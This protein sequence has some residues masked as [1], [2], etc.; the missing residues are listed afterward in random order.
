MKKFTILA[1]IAL[2]ILSGN[3]CA[4]GKKEAPRAASGSLVWLD[5]DQTLAAA[6]ADAK[7]VVVDVYTDWCGWCKVMDEKTYSDP[8]VSELMQKSFVAVKLNAEGNKTVSYLGKGYTETELARSFNVSGYP[9]TIFLGS[10]GSVLEKIPGYIEAP[11]FK[12]VLDYFDSDSYKN[13]SL[14]QYI[15]GKQ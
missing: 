3:S 6:D 11:I 9:T 2:A 7:F 14:D 12:K 15:T 8:A 1:M 10:D 5:W 13:T 4:G